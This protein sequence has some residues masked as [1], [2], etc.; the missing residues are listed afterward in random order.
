LGRVP[1]AGCSLNAPEGS[2]AALGV[3]AEEHRGGLS[4]VAAAAMEPAVAAAGAVAHA[5]N[6]AAVNYVVLNGL[7]G[8]PERI[9][10]DLDVVVGRGEGTRA[11]MI[12]AEVLRAR[13]WHVTHPPDTWGLR[14]VAFSGTCGLEI[15]T[16]ERLAWGVAVLYREPRSDGSVGP[17]RTDSHGTFVKRVA[18]PLLARRYGKVAAARVAFGGSGG[19]A[20]Q[21][22]PLLPDGAAEDEIARLARRLA[23]GTVSDL[24]AVRSRL[25][26][27]VVRRAVLGDLPEAAAR[28]VAWIRTR[29]KRYRLQSGL[30]VALVGPDGVGKSSVAAALQAREGGVFTAVHVRHWRP[31][32]LPELGRLAG[33]RP[34]PGGG[35]VAPRRRAGRGYWPRLLYYGLDFFLGHHLKD[36]WLLGRQ[37]L[38]LYDRAFL[39]ML[40][41]PVRYG[42]GSTAGMMGV[43]RM[44][45]RPDLV[46]VLRDEPERMHARKPELGVA[47]IRRQLDAWRELAEA[48]AV[49]VVDV[50][51]PPD[52]VA[53]EVQRLVVDAFVARYAKRPR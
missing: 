36:R 32:L 22:R 26:A 29:Y 4:D 2:A 12:A 3:A 16:L 13:G 18:L 11:L 39:D 35:P 38:L 41:D 51:G 42:L 44:L 40:V 19:I 1:R 7:D 43:Y 20:A 17:F 52:V 8:Y 6:A 25:A 45:P 37:R 27:M 31:G 49:Q 47:E 10:R 23:G 30:T 50:S 5:W 21:L 34:K 15:H 46:V 28:A 24:E 9:G 14:I 53:A 33:R 48:G